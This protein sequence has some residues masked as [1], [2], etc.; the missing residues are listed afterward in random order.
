MLPK[1]EEL[2]GLSPD[3]QAELLVAPLRRDVSRI[4]G[5]EYRAL[6]ADVIRLAISAQRER[7][8]QICRRWAADIRALPDAPEATREIVATQFE[9]AAREILA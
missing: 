4:D 7:D 5:W 3:E 9:I 1:I 6:V 2:R 8:A